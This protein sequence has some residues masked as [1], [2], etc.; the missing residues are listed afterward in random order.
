MGNKMQLV[1]YEKYH[2]GTKLSANVQRDILMRDLR[3]ILSERGYEVA[4]TPLLEAAIEFSPLAKPVA[5]KTQ[6]R[7]EVNVASHALNC[8]GE[9]PENVSAVF[10]EVIGVLPQIGYELG[11]SVV[12]FEVLATPVYETDIPPAEL[13]RSVLRLD[14][15][16]LGS[17]GE[18]GGLEPTSIQISTPDPSSEE[19]LSVVIEKNPTSPNKRLRLR[20]RFLTHEVP[21]AQGFHMNMSASIASL[22]ASMSTG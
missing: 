13:L 15:G 20:I 16:L 17:V 4:E 2:I 3:R 8:V 14:A 19:S 5:S 6:V 7:I 10:G 9:A 21:S 11:S 12:F 18:V 1:G 22:L